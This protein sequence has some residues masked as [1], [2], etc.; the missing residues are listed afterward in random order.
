MCHQLRAAA[1]R[2]E[3]AAKL[4]HEAGGTAAPPDV[5]ANVQVRFGELQQAAQNYLVFL[6]S[7]GV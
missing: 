2:L 6:Q 3:Q 7:I 4:A 5:R 1:M